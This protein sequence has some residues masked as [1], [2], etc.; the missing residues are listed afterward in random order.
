MFDCLASEPAVIYVY[1]DPSQFLTLVFEFGLFNDWFACISWHSGFLETMSMIPFFGY[2]LGLRVLTMS[3]VAP[4]T[5]L[6]EVASVFVSEVI[7][8]TSLFLV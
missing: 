2:I 8:L 3:P 7:I 4:P 5:L 1:E 6:D